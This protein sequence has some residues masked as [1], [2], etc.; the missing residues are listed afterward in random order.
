MRQRLGVLTRHYVVT[1]NDSTLFWGLMERMRGHASVNID[2]QG[3]A[4]SEIYAK[5]T[6]MSTSRQKIFTASGVV[7][8]DHFRTKIMICGTLILLVQHRVV[9]SKPYQSHHE[10]SIRNLNPF[11][12]HEHFHKFLLDSEK[13]W[14]DD[15]GRYY[16]VVRTLCSYANWDYN[17]VSRRPLESIHFPEH[18]KSEVMD[19]ARK[20]LESRERYKAKK[21]EHRHRRGYLFSGIPGTG[22]T[23][24]AYAIAAELKLALYYVNLS[25]KAVFENGALRKATTNIKTPAVILFEDV[26][27]AGLS[28]RK[29]GGTIDEKNRLGCVLDALD[30]LATE[31]GCIIILTTNHPEQLDEALTRSGRID[32]RFEFEAADEAQ[33]RSLFDTIYDDY[34]S[35][36]Y[37]EAIRREVQDIALKLNY[38]VAD[39]ESLFARHI[40]KPQQA[41]AA[42]RHICGSSKSAVEWWKF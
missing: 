6:E 36:D 39:C 13:Q 20:F 27:C 28:N 9:D 37:Y 41:A 24:C 17:L 14:R 25:Q 26:D 4:R 19:D 11:T 40:D 8:D 42:L 2:H 30:S 12:S 35:N 31:P 1:S 15:I 10:L 18:F 29:T 21:L 32:V 23:T 34:R 5:G 38:T 16:S 22:K 3:V 33:I 7:F